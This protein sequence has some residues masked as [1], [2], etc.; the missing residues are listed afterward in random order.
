MHTGQIRFTAARAVLPA[1]LD[2]KM[3]STME[4]REVKIIMAMVGRVKRSRRR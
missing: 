1:K 3:P 2:T 4:Y